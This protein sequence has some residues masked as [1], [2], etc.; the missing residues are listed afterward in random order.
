MR[1]AALLMLFIL[2]CSSGRH[3]ETSQANG[4]VASM[5]AG[6]LDPSLYPSSWPPASQRRHFDTVNSSVGPLAKMWRLLRGGPVP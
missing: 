2:L 4:T 3:A 1:L 6:S 5:G